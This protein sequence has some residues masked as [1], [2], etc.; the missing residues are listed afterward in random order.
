MAQDAPDPEKITD[1]KGAPATQAAPVK[2]AA[3]DEKLKAEQEALLK[4]LD[5]QCQ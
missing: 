1:D 4:S 3:D 5:C 2:D